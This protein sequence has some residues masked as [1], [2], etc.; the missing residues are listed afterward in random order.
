VSNKLWS[1]TKEDI[2]Y[3]TPG[4]LSD[5]PNL[6]IIPIKGSVHKGASGYENIIYLSDKKYLIGTSD[7]YL[8]VNLN[9]IKESKTFKISINKVLN[10]E[11]ES[12]K[13]RLSLSK[14]NNFKSYE[15]NFEFY[16][17]VPNYNK[18]SSIKYQY[19]LDGLNEKWSNLS[20]SSS[21]L[22][23]NLPY[24]SYTFKV[25][26]SIDNKLSDNVAA[27]SFIIDKPW[28][29]NNLMVTLYILIFIY[30]SYVVNDLH[31]KYYRNQR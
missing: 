27:Y 21:L 31:R 9:S 6:E 24:G 25:R 28:Y 3:F 14:S 19:H 4:K 15:N 18:T 2:R 1:F 7:G 22:F 11:F 30:L 13:N 5:E 8:I 17:S 16:Y 29:V 10:H 20:N 23:E 12:P 26:A